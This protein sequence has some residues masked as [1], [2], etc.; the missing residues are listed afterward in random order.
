MLL[1][2]VLYQQLYLI[3]LFTAVTI[4][5]GFDAVNNF[6]DTI[7]GISILCLVR[8]VPYAL[9]FSGGVV[10]LLVLIFR[11]AI[12][13]VVEVIE[14]VVEEDRVR[15]SEDYRPSWVPAIVDK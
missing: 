14:E 9:L 11:F 1:S 4:T 10:F 15:Q 8:P 12:S 5:G 6:C 3:D 13:L 2:F 7:F